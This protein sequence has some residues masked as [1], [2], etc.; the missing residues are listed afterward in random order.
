M[1]YK[2]LVICALLA[3]SSMVSAEDKEA[4]ALA[5]VGV[6]LMTAG[7]NDKARE[8]F[9][10]ALAHDADC[11]VAL[12]E[13]G[14][15]YETDGNSAAAADFLARASVEFAKG[16]K[17]NPGYTKMADCNRR[18]KTLNPYAGQFVQYME[19]Y[20]GELGKIVKKSP[21]SMTATE[22]LHRVDVLM[23]SSVIAPEKM[24]KIDR[25]AGAKT[26]GPAP[27]RRS[28]GPEG[29]K[30]KTV[31]TEVPPDVERAL[32]AAGWTTITGVWK[33]TGE[34]TYEVT[35]GKLETPKLNGAIQCMVVKGGTG[36]I[37]AFVRAQK[38]SDGIDDFDWKWGSRGY[39]VVIKNMNC[40]VYSPTQWSGNTYSPYLDHELALPD[41]NA[42][43]H[44]IVQIQEKRLEITV[45]NKREKLAE[46]P[47][48]KEGT[49]QLQIDG[50]LTIENPQAAGQ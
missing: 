8:V 36:T 40:K 32:K 9:F 13:L 44:F 12:H 19:D 35:D 1:K 39:G 16:E 50:T 26:D 15:M 7:K 25:P 48:A 28:I 21:D 2:S 24:P 27:V 6:N 23:M 14:K 11:A 37:R 33:K 4:G 30:E 34:K 49:F 22:A 41:A 5:E 20:A 45:N 17:S 43:N 3:S 31:K 18:L 10:K 38:E 42:K 46:Y 29:F 47:I